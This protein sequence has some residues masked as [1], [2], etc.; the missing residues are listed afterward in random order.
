MKGNVIKGEDQTVEHER[1]WNV[2]K[3]KTE[4]WVSEY[5]WE[6]EELAIKW[7]QPMEQNGNRQ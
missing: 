7:N 2:S 1:E 4:S 3:Q 6:M 5:T